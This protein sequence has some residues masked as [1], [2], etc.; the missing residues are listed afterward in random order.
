MSKIDT[1]PVSRRPEPPEWAYLTALAAS[2]G[3]SST[4]NTEKL[5]ELIHDSNTLDMTALDANRY[6]AF[7]HAICESVKI[8]H[9]EK[10]RAG[11]VSRGA[12]ILLGRY[13]DEGD[14][15]ALSNPLLF[16]PAAYDVSSKAVRALPAP[17]QD[18]GNI[19][20]L[21]K[22]QRHDGP[23]DPDFVETAHTF[24][25]DRASRESNSNLGSQFTHDFNRSL[26][27]GATTMARRVLRLRMGGLQGTM[28]TT[29][30]IEFIRQPSVK[31]VALQACSLSIGKVSAS[32]SLMEIVDGNAKYINPEPWRRKIIY[33]PDGSVKTHIDSKDYMGDLNYRDVHMLC[34]AAQVKGAVPLFVDV[35]ADIIQVAYQDICQ[36]A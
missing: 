17:L 2:L 18:V 33:R 9:G 21:I 8:M 34:P 1:L 28:P 20:C 4:E 24:Q 5:S 15:G 27:A 36:Q 14:F 10:E 22:K 12:Q 7:G 32:S 16:V 3:E 25:L 11:L 23:S 6:Y 19:L 31:S 13:F 26:L 30:D 35:V 29:E